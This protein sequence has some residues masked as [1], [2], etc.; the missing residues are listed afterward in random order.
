MERFGYLVWAFIAFGLEA[1]ILAIANGNPH[2]PPAEYWI[3]TLIVVLDVVI[4]GH[5]IN[6]LSPRQK[7]THS[8]PAR[9]LPLARRSDTAGLAESGMERRPISGADKARSV[10]CLGIWAGAVV[11]S[12]AMGMFLL[13]GW[14][15]R[16]VEHPIGRAPGLPLSRLLMLPLFLGMAALCFYTAYAL[17]QPLLFPFWL[18]TRPRREDALVSRPDESGTLDLRSANLQ[19]WAGTPEPASVPAVLP[20]ELP[21]EIIK[22]LDSRAG[23]GSAQARERLISSGEYVPLWNRRGRRNALMLIAVFV[24]VVAMLVAPFGLRAIKPWGSALIPACLSLALLLA[25]G[26]PF[27]LLWINKIA[28]RNRRVCPDLEFLAELPPFKPYSAPAAVA[29]RRALA[30]LASVAPEIIR[31]NESPDSY[32]VFSLGRPLLIEF[33]ALLCEQPNFRSDP[34]GLAR[35]I[36]AFPRDSVADLAAAVAASGY[37]LAQDGRD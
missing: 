35:A 33:A 21:M 9:P 10:G 36:A 25:I 29:V 17:G 8:A 4:A 24:A 22:L 13:W 14:W 5:V 6:R 12:V 2:A 3:V 11:A 18:A 16:Y 31:P 26:G 1:F 20:E 30:S 7:E 32:D 27:S 34:V 23:L 28:V 15:Y 19:P 37:Y